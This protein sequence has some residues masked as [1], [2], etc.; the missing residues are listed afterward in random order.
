M[1]TKVKQKHGGAI[2]R[3]GK[4]ECGNS[5]GRPRKLVPLLK[6]KGYSPS[7]T[8]DMLRNVQWMEL[9]EL[10]AIHKDEKESVLART[11]AKAAYDAL[12]KGDLSVYE[13]IWDRIMGKPKQIVEA[14]VTS[15]SVVKTSVTIDTADPVEAAKQYQKMM[16]D[17]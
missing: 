7:Q 5:K 12:K 13:K 17:E 3:W 11:L 15:N 8:L 14:D 9:D 2:N 1:G 10:Q 4:G 16:R 6:D